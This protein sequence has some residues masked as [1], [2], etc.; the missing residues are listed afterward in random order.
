MKLRTL[1]TPL[2]LATMVSACGTS[3]NKMAS[4]HFDMDSDKLT[5]EE[6]TVLSNLAAEIKD[7]ERYERGN[8]LRMNEPVRV[9][10]SGYTDSVGNP[11]YN[12]ELSERRVEYVKQALIDNGV[13][14]YLF[15]TRA[16]G[17]EE[18]IASIG[19]ETHD[20]MNRRVD[21]HISR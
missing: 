16:V 10:L 3:G 15:S 4:V 12:R 9:T 11:D 7:H 14:P 13:E 18:A 19:D 6:Q 17:E 8:D 5:W 20:P 21:I 1:I 2:M